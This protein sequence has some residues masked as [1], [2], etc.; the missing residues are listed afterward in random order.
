MRWITLCGS[1]RRHSFNARLLQAAAAAAPEG[2][3]IVHAPALDTLPH[4]SEDLE[5]DAWQ[6]GPVAALADA[7]RGADGLLVAT[8]EYNQ[9]IPGVLKNARDWLSR[10]PGRSLLEGRRA[11]L[12]G[13]TVGPWGT[14]VAQAHLRHVLGVAGVA[15][16]P[17]P[18]LVAAAA[19]HWLPCGGD[20]SAHGTPNPRPGWAPGWCRSPPRGNRRR[21]AAAIRGCSGSDPDPAPVRPIA[22]PRRRDR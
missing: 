11:A 3:A 9:S 22:G 1:T 8:P 17:R 7:V 19:R 10:H 2:V 12:M 16:F 5:P 15:V 14:R 13:A 21:T 6:A 18:L 20:A 4:F